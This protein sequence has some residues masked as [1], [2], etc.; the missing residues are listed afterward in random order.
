MA[1]RENSLCLSVIALNTANLA[2]FVLTFRE[3][4]QRHI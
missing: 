3:V 2:N 4:V 1:R